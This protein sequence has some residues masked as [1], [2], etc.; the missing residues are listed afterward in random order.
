MEKVEGVVDELIRRQVERAMSEQ[1]SLKVDKV[2]D[3]VE[4]CGRVA[5]EI[6]KAQDVSLQVNQ[7]L[8]VKSVFEEGRDIVKR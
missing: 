3:E 1:V 7:H 5:A 4:G 6:V 8:L 2:E